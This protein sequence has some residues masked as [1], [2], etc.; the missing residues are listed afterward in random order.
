MIEAENKFL[1]QIWWCQIPKVKT[2]AASTRS[3]VAYLVSI[4]F[5]DLEA[6]V[7]ERFLLQEN[8]IQTNTIS[9][10]TKDKVLV[11]FGK[12]KNKS[13]GKEFFQII[14]FLEKLKLSKLHLSL[15]N[16]LSRKICIFTSQ[17]ICVWLSHQSV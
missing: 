9:I 7:V 13:I 14:F 16:N 12:H 1:I 8:D 4:G 10:G 15:C 2:I 5:Y 6:Q 3:W 17:Y 11:P